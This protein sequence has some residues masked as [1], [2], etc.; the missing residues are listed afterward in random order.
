MEKK[1]VVVLTST[2]GYVSTNQVI[3]EIPIA[4]MAGKIGTEIGSFLLHIQP[5]TS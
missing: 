5:T 2:G 3:Q 1:V 4:S